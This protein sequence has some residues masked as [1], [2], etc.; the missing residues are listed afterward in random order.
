MSEFNTARREGKV[1]FGYD[2]NSLAEV[3]HTWGLTAKRLPYSISFRIPGA[4][5]TIALLLSENGGHGWK[6][7]PHRGLSMDSRGHHQIVR[8]DEVNADKKVSEARCKKELEK[9]LTRYVFWRESRK[10]TLWYKYHG[11][12]KIDVEAT[13]ASLESGDNVCVYTKVADEC[14]CPKADWCLAEISD[15]EFTGYANHVVEAVLQDEISYR[16]AV[17]GGTT[18]GVKVWP[19]Q[20]LL[21]SEVTSDGE[22]VVCL[23]AD[24]NLLNGVKRNDKE[25]DAAVEF[26]IPRRDFEL[27]YFRVL[28]GEA[29]VSDTY[30]VKTEKVENALYGNDEPIAA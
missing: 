22:K 30:A 16:I 15:A 8:I 23:S 25:R 20:K 27:G 13:K 14:P 11:V 29:T 7:I 19:G 4:E 10:G 2:F 5:N 24:E 9:P 18:G 1:K 12:F 3:T 28:P 17:K 6:N 26:F 21:V